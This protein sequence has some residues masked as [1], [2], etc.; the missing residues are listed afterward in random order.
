MLHQPEFALPASA[1][2]SIAAIVA[3]VTGAIAI[4]DY[5]QK[6]TTTAKKYGISSGT[7]AGVWIISY[8]LYRLFK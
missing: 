7:F 4:R 6:D 2:S 3:L 8:L 5:V 1:A